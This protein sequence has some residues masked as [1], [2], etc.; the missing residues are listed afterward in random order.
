EGRSEACSRQSVYGEAG[1]PRIDRVAVSLEDAVKRRLQAV[2]EAPGVY[3]FRDNRSQV[4]YV[5]KA[6]RLRDRLRSYFTPGNAQTARV[7]ELIRKATDFEFVTTANEVEALVLECNLIKSYR[8]RFNIR[9]KDDK[10]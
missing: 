7:A 4:I 3:L 2:P 8:P 5:G 9:L 1:L 10:N 6:L